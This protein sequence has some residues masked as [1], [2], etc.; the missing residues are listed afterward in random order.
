[1]SDYTPVKDC[2]EAA[3]NGRFCAGAEAA[4]REIKRLRE[5]LEEIG[6]NEIIGCECCEEFDYEYFYKS[7]IKTAQEALKND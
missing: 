1:M 7:F 6:E 2:L 4:V 5:A 3:R